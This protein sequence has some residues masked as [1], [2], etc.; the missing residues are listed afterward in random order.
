VS[1]GRS[2]WAGAGDIA[3]ADDLVKA[4]KILKLNEKIYIMP[5]REKLSHFRANRCKPSQASGLICP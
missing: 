3:V 5:H 2:Q 1:S 4:D